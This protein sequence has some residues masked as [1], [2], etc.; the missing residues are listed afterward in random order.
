MS[1]GS[2]RPSKQEIEYFPSISFLTNVKLINLWRCCFVFPKSFRCHKRFWVG[3]KLVTMPI[4]NV[5]V[6]INLKFLKVCVVTG[7]DILR[8]K[9]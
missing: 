7:A 4:V 2:H 5:T 9:D 3:V 1:V 8:C 6:W